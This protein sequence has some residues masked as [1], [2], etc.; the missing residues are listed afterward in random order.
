ML[1]KLASGRLVRFLRPR[2]GI[3]YAKD[4]RHMVRDRLELE[5]KREGK[6]RGKTVQRGTTEVLQTDQNME[7]DR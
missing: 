5:E 7:N 6:R 2:C 3:L 4:A 1:R